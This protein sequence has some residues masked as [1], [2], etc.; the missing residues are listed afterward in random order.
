M[1]LFFR[2]SISLLASFFECSAEDLFE[3]LVVLSEILLPVKSPVAS[4]LFQAVFIASVVDFLARSRS[5]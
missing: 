3:I 5:F 2:T 1:Y 4:S